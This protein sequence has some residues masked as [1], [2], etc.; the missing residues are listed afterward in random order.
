[1]PRKKVVREQK[2]CYYNYNE[3]GRMVHNRYILRLSLISWILL[4]LPLRLLAGGI[5]DDY[6]IEGAGMGVEGSFLVKVTLVSKKATVND[7]DFIRCAVHG[8]LF[9]GFESQQHRQ[10]Q[11]AFVDSKQEEEHAGFYEKFFKSDLSGY[12]EVVEGSRQ[13]RMEGKNYRISS[14]IQ[15]FKDKLRRDLEEQGVIK[16]LTSGFSL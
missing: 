16:K 15:V 12:A 14:V 3:Q 6:T 7:G 8:V 2:S 9:R 5:N 10:Y 4:T 11:R 13:V 1:M